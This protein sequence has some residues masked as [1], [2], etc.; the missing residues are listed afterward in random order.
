[1]STAE[2]SMRSVVLLLAVV[3][4][5]GCAHKQDKEP[6][7]SSAVGDY[8]A[9]AA[10]DDAAA[11]M[12]LLE[13]R[14]R[15]DCPAEAKVRF[16]CGL[17]FD[18]V[19]AEPAIAE[20]TGEICKAD[21]LAPDDCK[22]RWTD[23]YVARL[24]ERYYLVDAARLDVHCRAY[25]VKCRKLR[26]LEEWVLKEHNKVAQERYED[27]LARARK[28]AAEE[29]RAEREAEI[30]AARE[31]AERKKAFVGAIQAAATMVSSDTICRSYEVGGGVVTGC[32]SR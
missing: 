28:V 24:V 9:H 8:L 17:V 3:S 2:V 1:M 29:A 11:Q 4:A 15:A 10:L 16:R 13:E 5:V 23:M 6:T 18:D 30:Q 32:N 31:D 7:Q 19:T 26:P 14:W 21:G 25:P 20:F 27:R 22:A 12:A